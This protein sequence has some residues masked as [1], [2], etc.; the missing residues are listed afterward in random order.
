MWP[1]FCVDEKKVVGGIHAVAPSFFLFDEKLKCL[2]SALIEGCCIFSR[3]SHE[4]CFNNSFQENG[5]KNF[6][7]QEYDTIFFLF[8]RMM[9]KIF[10]R[11]WY[12]NFAVETNMRC[13]FLD[14]CSIRL[15][16]RSVPIEQKIRIDCRKNH[17]ICTNSSDTSAN[18][19][20]EAQIQI[21]NWL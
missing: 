12:K 10:S 11:E 6:S 20:I 14:E 7:F 5:T 15:I 13:K 8:Q 4:E 18:M 9:Q 16:S 21:C 2:A 17:R 3:F 1:N 19:I